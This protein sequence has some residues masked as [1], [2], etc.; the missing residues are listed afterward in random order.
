MFKNTAIKINWFQ[1]FNLPVLFRQIGKMG[2]GI[3][4]A[5]GI[6]FVTLI[7]LGH[8][9]FPEAFAARTSIMAWVSFVLPFMSL[10]YEMAI[11]DTKENEESEKIL[12]VSIY[13]TL[14]IGI[15]SLLS[16]AV[17]Q[18]SNWKFDIFSPA[19]QLILFGPPVAVAYNCFEIARLKYIRNLMF[20]NIIK[21]TILRAIAMS[22]FCIMG[23]LIISSSP[24][25]LI[26]GE[27]CGLAIGAYL[28]LRSTNLFV[29]PRRQIISILRKFSDC[30]LKLLPGSLMDNAQYY[31]P[32]LIITMLADKNLLGQYGYATAMAAAPVALIGRAAGSVFLG[33]SAANQQNSYKEL[34]QWFIMTSIPIVAIFW[35]LW[36]ASPFLFK[37]IIGSDWELAGYILRYLCPVFAAQAIVGPISLVLIGHGAYGELFKAQSILFLC[38]LLSA[39]LSIVFHVTPM[40]YLN[41]YSWMMFFAYVLYGYIILKT[42]RK[43]AR[44]PQCNQFTNIG[45]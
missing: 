24:W 26:M 15:L 23:G 37:T 29:I 39:T 31:I 20:G 33:R 35:V 38:T 44:L 7:I 30:P 45:L 28:F 25:I 4:I 3:V 5:Q 36:M 34:K 41:I 43:A 16:L 17:Y 14:T 42:A 27:F 13:V 10:R 21:I 2:G 40:I 19:G 11:V 32:I 18:Q 22:V 12:I 6:Q 9:F 8:I 1:Y